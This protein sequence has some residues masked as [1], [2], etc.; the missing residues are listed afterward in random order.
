MSCERFLII[1]RFF[2]LDDRT[3]RDPQDPMSPKRHV[4]DKFSIE[5]SLCPRTRPHP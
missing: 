2:R 5:A 3:R 1:K 4:W